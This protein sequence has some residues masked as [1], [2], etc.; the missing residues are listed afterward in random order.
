MT[1]PE[2]CALYWLV[3]KFDSYPKALRKDGKVA[4]NRLCYRCP[5][6]DPD[7]RD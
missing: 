5:K 7:L 1:H 2:Q 4:K 6:L 3:D